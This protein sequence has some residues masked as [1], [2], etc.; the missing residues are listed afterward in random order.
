[1]TFSFGKK[2]SHYGFVGVYEILPFQHLSKAITCSSK[3]TLPNIRK[4]LVQVTLPSP[5]QYLA[6]FPKV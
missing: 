3:V 6:L 4:G 2:E 1:M 5:L